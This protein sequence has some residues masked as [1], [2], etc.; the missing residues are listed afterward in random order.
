MWRSP[1]CPYVD[2]CGGQAAEISLK[3]NPQ[4]KCVRSP[5]CPYADNCGG[6]AANTFPLI[7]TLFLINTFSDLITN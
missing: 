6:Q 4:Q 1:Q 3:A 7:P 5:Q 2:N